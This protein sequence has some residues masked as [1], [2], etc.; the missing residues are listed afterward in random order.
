MEKRFNKLQILFDSGEHTFIGCGK[1]SSY[2]LMR[3]AL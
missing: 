2:L 3:K 1:F